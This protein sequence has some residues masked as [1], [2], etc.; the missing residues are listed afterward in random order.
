MYF[1][2]VCD[3]SF[4]FVSK[5]DSGPGSRKTLRKAEYPEMETRLYAWFCTQRS[6]HIPISY[7]IL[8][9]KAKQFYTETFGNDNFTASRGWISNFRKRHGLRALKV[10]GE[11]LS[12][13][14]SAVEPFITT[15]AEKIQQLNL[16]PAQIYNADESALYWKMLPEKTLV[17]SQEKTAPGRKI[18]KERITFLA[19]CNADGSQKLKLLVI[20]KA[21]NPR[22]FKN[23]N[24]PVEYK[25]SANA[26][27]TT[28]IFVQWFQCSFIPQ[29]RSHLRSLNLPE[30]ALLIVDNASSHGTVEELTSED[31]QFTTIFLPPNC[32]ALLQPMDQNAIRLIK[33]FYRKSLLAHILA[34]N[35]ENVVKLL[36]TINLKD[37][38]CL[39]CN[40]WEKVSSEVLQ[41]C[42]YKILAHV[43]NN[44][45]D[46]EYD[47]DDLIS[48]GQ[49]RRNMLSL[50][51]EITDVAD[52]L[53]VLTEQNLTNVEL[54]NWLEN[55]EDLLPLEDMDIAD[56]HHDNENEDP[57][58]NTNKTVKNDEA[59]KSFNVCIK[60]AEENNISLHDV[61]VL[62]RLKETAF[63]MNY[64]KVKQTKITNYFTKSN[65][66]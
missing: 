31:G 51:E 14:Q 20:G 63:I 3:P 33:L 25:S 40:A 56:E 43:A 50:T 28:A 8:S 41:K 22:A 13:D 10:C 1:Y 47:A 61:L 26:W 38:V 46:T 35:E 66:T 53:N 18:S 27:M 7:E 55:D 54:C 65:K 21:K 52:M 64:K 36:K 16:S 39:L 37:A 6:R 15:F 24:V 2:Y 9:A 12:N 57:E 62:Q 59:V 58:L 29:V 42:W 11:K 49:L 17:R 45:P 44:D 30:R 19:C 23:V 5:C 34:S 60:W 48:L 32:T 4:R